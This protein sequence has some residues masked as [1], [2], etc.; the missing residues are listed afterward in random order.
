MIITSN[1][2]VAI[3]VQDIEKSQFWRQ[4]IVWP[5]PCIQHFK[6]W[7]T[8]TRKFLYEWYVLF[9]EKGGLCLAKFS[10]L[11]KWRR[12]V[13]INEWRIIMWWRKQRNE[14]CFWEFRKRTHS[15][16]WRV[17]KYYFL[18]IYFLIFGL[19]IIFGIDPY[20]GDESIS[21]GQAI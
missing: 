16:S 3:A 11:L 4:F 6:H 10:T 13:W 20:D 17:K 19:F 12:I 18:F 9:C 21:L 15:Q 7:A 2:R 1:A 14:F 8:V 5:W